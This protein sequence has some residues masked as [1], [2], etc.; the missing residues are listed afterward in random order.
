MSDSFLA[1]SGWVIL[2]NHLFPDKCWADKKTLPFF[3]C[4]DRGL[5]THFKYHKHKI[6]FFL[7]S[8]RRFAQEM[9][10]AGFSLTYHELSANNY[11][12][13]LLDW[14]QTKKIKHL[15]MWEIE[16]HFFQELMRRFCER[17]KL[18]FITQ[19]S[20][21]FLVK[22]AEFEDYLQSVSKP[23]MQTFYE[24]Q[25]L[26]SG[27]LMDAKH[28]PLGGKFSF[29]QDN[30]KKWN[31]R[32]TP[33]SLPRPRRDALTQKVCSL[34]AKE[35]LDHPGESENFWLVTNRSEAL[36]QLKI[37]IEQRLSLFGDYEDSITFEHDFLYHSVL[38]PYINIGFLPP[39]LIVS[40]IPKMHELK[41]PL[42]S[43]EG[44]IRQIMGWREFMRGIY[45]HYDSLQQ[46]SNFF[47]HHR[48]LTDDWYQGTTGILPLDLAIKKVQRLGYNHHIER[49]M[50]L[51][52]M[53]LL[54]EIH[55]QEVFRWF[56]EMYVDSS[57]WVMGPNVF[58][59]GQFSDGG[60]FA[61]KPYICGS[62]YIL[63][64]SQGLHNDNNEWCDIMDGLY[65][66]FIK[67]HRSFFEQNHRMGAGIKYLDRMDKQRGKILYTAAE[68]FLATKTS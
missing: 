63:K 25:R 58:G 67:K 30:R 9:K 23:K 16:D 26:K 35:F 62:N 41:I 20:P 5:C 50:I 22:R 32:L 24:R 17:H 7:A 3:M 66:R 6:I 52:N 2:G 59:M 45:H 1:H 27:V 68:N 14:V 42:N 37:F 8:M 65:W 48:K 12:D 15:Y 53:M 44:F 11:F 55:P 29:D 18:S 10:D 19:S 54:S 36:G 46:E 51:S 60:I 38:S 57:D 34:V 13:N 43:I 33:P 31:S 21:L 39:G 40:A 61:T 4:E 28:K 49:L 56:M 64:M 47:N